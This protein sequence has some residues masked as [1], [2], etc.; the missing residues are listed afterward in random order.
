MGVSFGNPYLAA[1]LPELS[2]YLAAY[3]DQAVLQTAAA[4]ALFGESE[5]SGRLPVSIPGVA[6][7]GSGI[8]KPRA[9]T[10]SAVPRSSLSV[11]PRR[12]APGNPIPETQGVL[13]YAPDD[14][15]GKA[16]SR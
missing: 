8:T 2:T 5:L 10:S 7:R 4:R 12:A 6:A 9:S 16:A 14:R 15:V 3:G 11:I 13:R 1:D